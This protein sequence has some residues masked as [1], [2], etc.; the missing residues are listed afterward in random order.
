[1]Y[2]ENEGKFCCKRPSTKK[3]HLMQQQIVP[4]WVDKVVTCA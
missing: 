2:E 4:C 1:M 3:L